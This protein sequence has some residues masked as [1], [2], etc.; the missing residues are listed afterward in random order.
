VIFSTD[1]TTGFFR[2]AANQVGVSISGTELFEFNVNGLLFP[3]TITTGSGGQ[4]IIDAQLINFSTTSNSHGIHLVTNRTGSGV[5]GFNS[6]I[7]VEVPTGSNTAA[8]FNSA[9]VLS[10]SVAGKGTSL[11]GNA[12]N[13]CLSTYTNSNTAI[14]HNYGVGIVVEN[15]QRN[16]GV[17]AAVNA[18]ARA[19]ANSTA[20]HGA[21]SSPGNTTYCAG[22]FELSTSAVYY[23]TVAP[24]IAALIADNGGTTADILVARDN[25]TTVFSVIDGGHTVIGGDTT[26]SELRILEASGSGTNY[27]AFKAQAQAASVTY[28]L[29]AADG[30]SGYQLTTNGSGT[31]TWAAAGGSIPEL[32]SD[33]GSP[34]AESAWVL[35]TTG[36]PTLSHS[37]VTLGLTLP[38]SGVA[39][40]QFSY[41][42]LESTTVRVTLT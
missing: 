33:P 36:T 32:T 24:V 41:R 14:G 35:F 42:T 40:Y 27:S 26:A 2:P 39:S 21:A 37:I 18:T 7:Y 38:G 28:T 1:T 30:T 11:T 34:T 20:V 13:V 25:A 10:V 6:G 15:G 4:S 16:V 22:F 9:M 3:N 12:A 8:N 5:Q 31:L 29:P 17:T 19:T 23:E